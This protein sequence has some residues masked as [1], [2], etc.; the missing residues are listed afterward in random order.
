M[1]NHRGLLG[2]AEA[3]RAQRLSFVALL[4][5]LLTTLVAVAPPAFSTGLVLLIRAPRS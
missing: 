2:S 4:I 3:R 1:N 5:V